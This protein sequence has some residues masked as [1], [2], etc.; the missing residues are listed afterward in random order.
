MSGADALAREGRPPRWVR[1]STVPGSAPLLV[2]GVRMTIA[3][4]SV[5]VDE[6][7]AAFAGVCAP[8]T[9]T[10]AMR[11]ASA[12]A[13]ASEVRARIPVCPSRAKSGLGRRAGLAGLVDIDGLFSQVIESL[14]VCGPR[15]PTTVVSGGLRVTGGAATVLVDVRLDDALELMPA[16][17]AA[18]PHA[19]LGARTEPSEIQTVVAGG[20]QPG[21][22]RGLQRGE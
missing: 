19:L 11:T 22:E 15:R 12:S 2:F 5:P 13:T 3:P 21:G 10:S 8:G 7:V 4:V 9:M 20:V 14:G 16:R 17:S 6:L 18:P 1:S